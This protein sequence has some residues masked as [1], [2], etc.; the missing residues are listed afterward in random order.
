MLESNDSGHGAGNDLKDRV[1]YCTNIYT[2]F[3]INLKLNISDNK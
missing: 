2:F 3:A 1:D